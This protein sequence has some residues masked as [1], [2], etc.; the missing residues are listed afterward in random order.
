MDKDINYMSCNSS[1]MSREIW[2]IFPFTKTPVERKR[3]LNT[4]GAVHV[5]HTFHK[6]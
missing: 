3:D 6:Q 4:L 2:E 5:F 1:Q